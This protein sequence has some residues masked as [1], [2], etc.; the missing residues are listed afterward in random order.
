MEEVL[1]AW[2]SAVVCVTPGA[3]YNF[4]GIAEF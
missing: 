1:R 3:M 4:M 2:C